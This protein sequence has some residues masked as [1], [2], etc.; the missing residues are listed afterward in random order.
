MHHEWIVVDAG[1]DVSDCSYCPWLLQLHIKSVIHT[2]RYSHGSIIG[3][4]GFKKHSE[5]FVNVL[6]I[7]TVIIFVIYANTILRQSIVGAVRQICG[8]N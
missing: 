8:V 7:Y 6:F 2:L 4:S 5:C 3:V 1:A